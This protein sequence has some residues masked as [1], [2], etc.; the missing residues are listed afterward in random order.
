MRFLG[1]G[2]SCDLNSLYKS[3]IEAGHE[4]RVHIGEQM[5]HGVMAGIVR[6]VDSW[7]EHLDWVREAGPDG[8]ILFE[9]VAGQSGALQDRLRADGLNVIGGSAFG[10]RL[11]NDR[12]FGQEIMAGFGMRTARSWG[13]DDAAAAVSHIEANPGRY[14]L[15]FSGVEDFAAGDNYVGRMVDGR[16]VA[17]MVQARMRQRD[18]KPTRFILMDHVEG[19]EMGVGAYF[20]GHDFLEPACLDWEHKRFFPGDLGEL[21]GEMGTVATYCGTKSF[22]EATLARVA[23]LLREHGYL[24][25]ININTIVNA[26]GIW[27]LE[28]TCRF[29]YPGFAVLAPLQRTG[30]A[31]LFRSMVTRSST[32]FET[33]DGYSVGIVMTTRPFPFTRAW[34]PEELGLPVLFD[35]APTE[36]DIANL[37][38]GEMALDPSGQPVTAGF[39]GWTMVVTGLGDTVTEAQ[40]AAVSLADRIVIPDVRYRRDI[41]DK[42]ISGQLDTLRALGLYDG[43]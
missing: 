18:G 24:G 27:P 14:V 36:A 15:K 10:D 34:V 11:E 1:I 26:E 40:K 20:N 6:R 21:T 4:V 3:L 42:L 37:H 30:W 17:A 41:G 22:F 31:Q 43:R 12:T 8:I 29:G 16:D 13:F 7:Q 35:G 23:P 32:R 38:W 25:Y 5:C 2:E 9:S 33:H 39:H 19:V 28:F